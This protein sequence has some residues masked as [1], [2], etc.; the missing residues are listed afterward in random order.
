MFFYGLPLAVVL[1]LHWQPLVRWFP[2]LPFSSPNLRFGQSGIKVQR[3]ELAD[4]ASQ[5][6]LFAF[7]QDATFH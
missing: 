7:R 1:S 2:A 6:M 4:M 5:Y 3:I